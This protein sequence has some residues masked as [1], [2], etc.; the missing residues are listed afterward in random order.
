[1]KNAKINVKVEYKIDE[2]FDD[3]KD[4]VGISVLI[5]EA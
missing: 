1:M 5:E 4:Q 2:F 3:G